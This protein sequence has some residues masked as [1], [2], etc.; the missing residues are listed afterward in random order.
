MK[1]ADRFPISLSRT[2]RLRHCGLIRSPAR[3]VCHHLSQPLPPLGW[4]IA[5][6]RG[7]QLLHGRGRIGLVARE[8]R[9]GDPRG[10]VGQRHRDQ[11]CR[12]AFEQPGRPGLAGVVLPCKTDDS[13]RADDEQSPDIA[14]ALFADAAQALL[15]PAAVRRGVSPSQAANW[16]PERKSA[17][18]GIAAAI[19]LAVIGPI[20]GILAKRRLASLSRCHAK[21][22]LSALAI[23]TAKARS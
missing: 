1:S 11:S 2:E 22:R 5:V 18:S 20:P 4:R 12:L 15:S 8:D 16:R 14:V 10:L 9:P 7:E 17:A 6:Y 19:A 23:S 13:S 21:M 3:P